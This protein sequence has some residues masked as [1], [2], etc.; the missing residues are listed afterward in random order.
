MRKTLQEAHGAGYLFLIGF[1][2]VVA[3]LLQGCASSDPL[4][5]QNLERAWQVWEEDRRPDLP[6]EKIKAREFERDQAF[7]YED[8]KEG[9]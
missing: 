2:F 6:E 3:C 4:T 8:S 1:L 9:K 5:R 7:E